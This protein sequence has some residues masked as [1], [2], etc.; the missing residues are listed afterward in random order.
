MKT[1]SVRE[2]RLAFPSVLKAIKNGETVAI[3]SRRKIVATLCPPP[4]TP[5]KKQPWSDLDRRL[6]AQPDRASLNLADL[7]SSERDDV[8]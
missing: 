6:A 1:A 3:T 2:I 8:R 7:L 5:G 4:R